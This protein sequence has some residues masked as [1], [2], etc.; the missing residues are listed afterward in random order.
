MIPKTKIV[1][2]D[3]VTCTVSTERKAEHRGH[4]R[5]KTRFTYVEV[6]ANG[7]KIGHGIGPTAEKTAIARAR[8]H[9]AK[10]RGATAALAQEA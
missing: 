4:E 7:E 3:G 2:I 8:K 6:W 9:I 10:T 5:R 1:D